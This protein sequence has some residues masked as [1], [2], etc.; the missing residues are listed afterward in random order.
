MVTCKEHTEHFSSGCKLLLHY[1]NGDSDISLAEHMNAMR[2]YKDEIITTEEY[3]FVE[4]CWKLGSVNKQ[5]PGCY[6]EEPPDEPSNTTFYI[7]IGIIVVAVI[8]ILAN[9]FRK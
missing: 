3:E 2:D 5:C 4:D 8:L 9:Y 1:A 7:I 6:G